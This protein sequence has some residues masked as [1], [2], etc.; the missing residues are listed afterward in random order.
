MNVPKQHNYES[1]GMG[2][3]LYVGEFDFQCFSVLIPRS[4]D[5]PAFHLVDT[6]FSFVFLLL[7]KIVFDSY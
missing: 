6:F 1:K 2:L 3:Q 5:P 7:H 4:E